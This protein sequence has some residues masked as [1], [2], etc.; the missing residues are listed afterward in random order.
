[1]EKESKGFGF[2]K[3]SEGGVG[4]SRSMKTVPRFRVILYDKVIFFGNESTGV[5]Y[6]KVQI[7]TRRRRKG[8]M[9]TNERAE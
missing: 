1:M 5:L 2:E 9:R 3:V 8:M 4:R 6:S 7:D